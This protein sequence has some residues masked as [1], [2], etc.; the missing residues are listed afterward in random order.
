MANI[1]NRKDKGVALLESVVGSLDTAGSVLLEQSFLQSLNDVLS[2]N[3]GV[4]SGL[5]NEALELPARS[6]PTFSKQI[7]DMVDGTQRQTF[8]Y[9]NPLQSAK[10]NIIAKI[11]FA[12][13]T[14]A[15]SVDTMGRE[16]QK[17]GGKNNI[18]NVFLNPANVNTENIST[19]AKEIYDV[20]KAVGDKTVMPRVAPY[21]VD[22]KG[23]R[24]NLTPEQRA[25]YQKVAGNIIEESVDNMMK[26]SKY[27]NVPD[28][29]KAE[30]ITNIVNYAYNVAKK[31]VLGLEISNTYEKAYEYSKIGNVEDFYMFKNSVDDTNA[32][33]KRQSMLNY[34]TSSRL[35]QEQKAFLYKRYFDSDDIDTW[36]TAR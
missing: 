26:D 25:E 31:D 3:K 5:L 13:K 4:I 11:P 7:A 29:E 2:D 20:Y 30:I 10:N 28:K 22:S 17:Y 24:I 1:H 16:I 12:S 27:V 19:A 33:T 18:F 35:N 36:L 6:I 9:D 23:N 15:P 21:Y 32:A 8:V 14:L 34:F